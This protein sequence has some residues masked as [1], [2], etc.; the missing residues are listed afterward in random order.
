MSISL[1]SSLL[2]PKLFLSSLNLTPIGQMPLIPLCRGAALGVDLAA[3]IVSRTF[4]TQC[5]RALT[6]Q[7]IR[8]VLRASVGSNQYP[9]IHAHGQEVSPIDLHRQTEDGL[10]SVGRDITT[11]LS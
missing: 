5:G 9:P 11:F 6:P 7:E 3:D 1:S 4:Q 2:L 10:R 8:L